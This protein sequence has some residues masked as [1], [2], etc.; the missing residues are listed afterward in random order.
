MKTIHFITFIALILLCGNVMAETSGEVIIVDELN[1]YEW[2]QDPVRIINAELSGEGILT[3]KVEY[4]GGE[5]YHIFKIVATKVMLE[6]SSAQLRLLLS[7]D[8]NGDR[9][10]ERIEE[11][12]NFNLQPL[13][14]TFSIKGEI[15]LYVISQNRLIIEPKVLLN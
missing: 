10:K 1:F 8:N 13:F 12:V 14:T 11:Y 9:S 5:T 6:S 3:V 15:L 4:G 2:K 7:H